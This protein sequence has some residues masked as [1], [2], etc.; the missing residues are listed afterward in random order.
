MQ[1]TGFSAW[2]AEDSNENKNRKKDPNEKDILLLQQH[3]KKAIIDMDLYHKVR[4]RTS[5]CRNSLRSLLQ[6]AG[7][8]V[9]EVFSKVVNEITAGTVVL[10]DYV[11][12]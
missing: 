4:R 9:D 5:R 2:E 10:E 12:V 1:P 8:A 6:V 11:L 7:E 3:S